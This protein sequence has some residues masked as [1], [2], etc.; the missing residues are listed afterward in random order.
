MYHGFS[1]LFA[2]STCEMVA[3]VLA[4]LLHLFIEFLLLP[5]LQINVVPRDLQCLAIRHVTGIL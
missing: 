2:Y 4:V 1:F 5:F 3:G